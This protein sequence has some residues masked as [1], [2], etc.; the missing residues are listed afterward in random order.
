MRR[1]KSLIFDEDGA[2]LAEFSVA[3][4]AFFMLF[5]GI[6][7]FCQ[8]IYAGNMIA[9]AAQQGA[10][11]AMVRGSDWTTACATVSSYAC[12]TSAAGVQNY[13]LSLP[14]PGLRLF[15]KQ[16]YGH[17]FNDN[18]ERRRMHGMEPGL[19]GY[20]IHSLFIQFWVFHCTKTLLLSPFLS[21]APRQ[22]QFKIRVFFTDDGW[23]LR[24]PSISRS[25]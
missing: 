4:F 13:I 25:L 14:Q 5:F 16:H 24:A 22:R 20:D 21:T 11:Y 18:G 3:A 9:Y 10:R 15:V 17:S 8:V 19:P 12:Y 2:E 6:I 23:K 1:L 7:V